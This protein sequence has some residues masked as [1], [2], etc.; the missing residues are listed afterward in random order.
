MFCQALISVTT[1][2]RHELVVYNRNYRGLR[3][4]GLRHERKALRG[5]R[6]STGVAKARAI[7]GGR[8]TRARKEALEKAEAR[9][10]AERQIVAGPHSVARRRLLQGCACFPR[11]SSSRSGSVPRRANVNGGQYVVARRH[12]TLVQTTLTTAA[13]RKMRSHT[14]QK[15][16]VTPVHT[17]SARPPTA[18]KGSDSGWDPTHQRTGPEFEC[19]AI[20]GHKRQTRQRNGAQPMPIGRKCQGVPSWPENS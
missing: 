16:G 18:G 3:D 2:K 19:Q 8:G 6:V 10:W 12:A 14:S 7:R 13:A 15:V 1:S 17:P 4:A 5:R 20:R 9:S 11:R